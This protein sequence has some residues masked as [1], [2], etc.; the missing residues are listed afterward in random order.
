MK[1]LQAFGR[2]TLETRRRDHDPL[3]RPIWMQKAFTDVAV[4]RSAKEKFR[5]AGA[6]GIL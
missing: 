6:P 3:C 4:I 2:R 1:G 5:R